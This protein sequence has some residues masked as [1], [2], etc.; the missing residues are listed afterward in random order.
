MDPIMRAL[1]EGM[2]MLLPTVRMEEQAGRER[3]LMTIVKGVVDLCTGRCTVAGSI[4]EDLARMIERCQD[5]EEL[6][7]LS[8][9]VRDLMFHFT[10]DASRVALTENEA[11]VLHLLEGVERSR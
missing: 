6:R 10:P 4:V 9:Q 2:R 11:R 1:G 3:A 8:V 7:D 5:G